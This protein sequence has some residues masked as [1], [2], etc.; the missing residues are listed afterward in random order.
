MIV[1]GIDPGPE[2]SAYVVWDGGRIL[3]MSNT[4]NVDLRDHLDNDCRSL[5][6]RT[7]DQCVIEQIRGF[8]IPAGNDLL[9]TCWWSGRF[10]EA[11]GNA[12]MLPRK[13][14]LSHLGYGGAG[15][16]DA[17]VAAALKA[18]FGVSGTKRNPGVLYGVTGH[19]WAALAVSVCFWDRQNT[20]TS[21]GEVKL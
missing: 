16:K 6:G 18:R 12:I 20:A 15:N 8:G 5:V 4:S 17:A 1:I 2:E 11:W 19:L 13:E 9:D 3:S 7:P 14:V 10:C 21:K